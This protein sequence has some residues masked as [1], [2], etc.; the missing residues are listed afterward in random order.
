MRLNS[1]I[2]AIIE[3][4]LIFGL[5]L[6]AIPQVR[7]GFSANQVPIGQLSDLATP[8][9]YRIDMK[10]IPDEPRFSGHTEIDGS[11]NK[12]SKI[13]YLH[14]RDFG[15]A[16]AKINIGGKSYDAFYTQVDQTGVIKLEFAQKL[17]SGKFTLIFDY[18]GEFG[19]DAAG[20]YRV[21]VENDYYAWTQ[22]ESIDARA[23]FPSFDEPR[24]KTPFKI[25]ITTKKGQI[26]VSNAPEIKTTNIG[27]F[28]KHE[29][30]ETKPLPTYLVAMMAG[31]FVTLEGVAP[32]T[33]QRATPLPIR[34]IATKPNAN[35]M[36]FALRETPRIVELLEK[37]FDKPFPF[38]KLD[39]IA[40]PIMPGAMENAGADI[41]DD[42]ILLLDDNAPT[43][44]K[45][46][47]GMV[48]AHELSHQWFGDYVTPVWWDDIWLNES[49]ANWM[50]F[51]IGN[52]WRPELN[53]GIGSIDEA[54]TAMTTDA[55]KTGRPIHEK[56]TRNEDIDQ[57][58]DQITYGKGGQVVAMI[59]NF[60]GDETF[61]KGVRLHM[62]KHP[63]GSASTNDFFETLAEAAHDQRVLLALKSFVDQQGV[64]VVDIKRENNGFVATQYRYARLGTN[65]APQHWVIPLCIRQGET[66]K[67]E[68]LENRP[69][70]LELNANEAI[71]PNFGGLGYYRFNL[72]HDEW[73]KLIA[74]GDKLPAGEAL[75]VIDSL[76]A[77]FNAGNASM[78]DLLLAAKNFAN[79]PDSNVATDAVQRLSGLAV[80]GLIADKDLQNYNKIMAQIYGERLKSLGSELGANAY[81]NDDPDRQ[82]LRITLIETMAMDAHDGQLRTQ[83]ANAANAFIGGNQNALNPGL[84]NVAFQVLGEDQ[85][86]EKIKSI[87]NIIINSHN[88][89]LREEALQALNNGTTTNANWLLSQYQNKD[90]LSSERNEILSALMLDPKTRDMTFEW[91]KNNFDKI[92]KSNGIFAVQRLSNLPRYYCSIAKADEVETFF[93]PIIRADGR[94]E[95]SFNRMMEQIRN[96]ADLSDA[97]SAEISQAL[98]NAAK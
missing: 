36:A 32:P 52:E 20:L 95:L 21:K 70:K 92:G 61:Q 73:L 12:P 44:Q 7:G 98:T 30:E 35:K 13:I 55:L 60:L 22:F 33:P 29:F 53:I 38:P 83:L 49:F 86:D 89:L 25:S 74:V 71:I 27:E 19:E 9:Y 37:Y 94:G 4:V 28:D 56:I 82:K 85:G 64:P 5:F 78:D 39:Q 40:S 72:P 46:R 2:I 96:C 45:Q 57:S 3:A 43:T 93:R 16:K 97:K 88:D 66:K 76:W 80:R 24:H 31:P 6:I 1:K 77:Q 79:N 90:L 59:A 34:I 62:E 91:I 67:C 54:L 84:Y 8:S 14:G 75:A 68:F 48:V 15:N 65:F 47:F 41:Y 23:V 51:R 42:G 87:F 10:I 26:A 81:L 50:G 17:P 18:D 63:Y 11:L 58:F 69:L